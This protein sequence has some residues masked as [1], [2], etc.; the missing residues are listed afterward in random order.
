MLPKFTFFEL[1]NPAAQHN[2]STTDFGFNLVKRQ[3]ERSKKINSRA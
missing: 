1:P 3:I 2:I